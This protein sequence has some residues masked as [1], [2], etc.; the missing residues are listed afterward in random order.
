MNQALAARVE[1]G[2]TDRAEVD[3]PEVLADLAQSDEFAGQGISKIDVVSLPG[4]VSLGLNPAELHVVGIDHL[5]Q[6]RR[7]WPR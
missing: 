1:L 4:E 2:Q 6:D 3:I 5:R 7:I